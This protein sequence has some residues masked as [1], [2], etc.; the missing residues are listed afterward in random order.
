M[1]KEKTNSKKRWKYVYTLPLCLAMVFVVGKS[2]TL[3]A[4][5]VVNLPTAENTVTQPPIAQTPKDT[6]VFMVVEDM[7][8]FPG[9]IKKMMEYIG[10]NI[11]YPRQAAKDSIQGRVIV[12]FTVNT[13]GAIVDPRIVRGVEPSLDEVALNVV[14]NMPKWKP[15]KQGGKEVRVRYTLPVTFRLKQPEKTEQ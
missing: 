8:E 11:V 6:A 12:E 10:E 13:D 9:G 14:Q 3:Q 15:G 2:K 1:L 4:Q 5:P 7:P